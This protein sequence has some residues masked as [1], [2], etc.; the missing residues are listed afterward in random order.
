MT[1]PYLELLFTDSLEKIFP[2]ADIGPI[3]PLSF[4]SMFK[5]ERYSFQAVYRL[6]GD[7]LIKG[8]ITLSG[9]LHPMLQCGR[10]G[11]CRASC[12]IIRTGMTL[13]CAKRRG[14]IPI[15]LPCGCH[16]RGGGGCGSVG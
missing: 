9:S 11:W 15:S 10:W 1:N 3:Q 2:D 6:T 8:K 4:A 12:P 7:R 16:P 13:C 14:C 5:N